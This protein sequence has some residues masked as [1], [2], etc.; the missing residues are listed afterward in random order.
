VVLRQ[1]G[2]RPRFDLKLNAYEPDDIDRVG[3]LVLLEEFA[4]VPTLNA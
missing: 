4:R 1:L 2:Q 3:A